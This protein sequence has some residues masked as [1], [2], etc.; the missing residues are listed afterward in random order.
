MAL[1]VQTTAFGAFEDS[2][3]IP[4][5]ADEQ[6]DPAARKCV[7][8]FGPKYNLALAIAFINLAIPDA[9][10]ATG[11]TKL[12]EDLREYKDMVTPKPNPKALDKPRH[13][14]RSGG[15]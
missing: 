15:S 2:G 1:K 14:P 10:G 8:C 6:A 13:P 5:N 4:I 3:T 12:V 9:Q 11:T 7:L